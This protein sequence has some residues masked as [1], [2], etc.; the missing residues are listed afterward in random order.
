ML[1]KVDNLVKNGRLNK[2]IGKVI[3]LLNIRM[4]GQASKEGT[5]ELLQ[6]ARGQKGGV[7]CFRRDSK[8]RL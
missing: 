1:A 8:G 7:S 6:K 2:L 4:V 3:G 5:L